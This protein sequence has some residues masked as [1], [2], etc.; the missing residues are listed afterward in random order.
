MK[1][2]ASLFSLLLVAVLAVGA[3]CAEEDFQLGGKG[4]KPPSS[5][6]TSGNTPDPTPSESGLGGRLKND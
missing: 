5:E 3:G 2:Y 1:P 6:S 4:K